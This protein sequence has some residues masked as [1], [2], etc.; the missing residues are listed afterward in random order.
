MRVR[1][2]LP[3]RSMRNRL[4]RSTENRCRDP[5]ALY[6]V[7]LVPSHSVDTLTLF[8]KISAIALGIIVFQ[9]PVFAQSVCYEPIA[10][11][12]MEPSTNFDSDAVRGRCETDIEN[13]IE[14]IDEYIQC[15]EGQVE[16]ARGER[17]GARERR[18]EI[19]EIIN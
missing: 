17:E 4:Y 13:Y 9:T 15:L 19:Q 16:T 14:K 7:A 12:C 1:G 18:K 5:S 6:I 8:Y 10:P 3:I 11:F 2:A